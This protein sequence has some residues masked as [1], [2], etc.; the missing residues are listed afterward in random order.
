MSGTGFTLFDTVV[1][2]CRLA[3]GPRGVLATQLPEASDDSTCAHLLRLVPVSI[4]GEGSLFLNFGD[5][6]RAD[7][8]LAKR[9]EQGFSETVLKEF[10]VAK[11][12]FD[13]LASRAVPESMAK[14][15][16]VF[17]VDVTKTD[18]SYGLR[19]SEF[20]ELLNSILPGSGR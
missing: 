13:D 5:K 12:Y 8:F 14:G 15:S 16:S 3:W 7:E 10:D 1:G 9:L 18:L 19:S 17:K 20:P 6:A 4:L 11:S 2:R